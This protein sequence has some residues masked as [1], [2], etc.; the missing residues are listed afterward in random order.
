MRRRLAALLLAVPAAAA[1][2]GSPDVIDITAVAVEG[3]TVAEC[4]D[5]AGRLA[6]QSRALSLAT[7]P[8]IDL[9][10]GM[11]TFYDHVMRLDAN[12]ELN[13]TAQLST[14]YVAGHDAGG[15]EHRRVVTP[16]VRVEVSRPWGTPADAPSRISIAWLWLSRMAESA[17]RPG[18]PLV[19]SPLLHRFDV[20]GEVETRYG[21]WGHAV[22]PCRAGRDGRW[23]GAVMVWTYLPP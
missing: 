15:V 14:V 2:Q 23:A 12:G 20:S 7:A 8:P 19:Q 21:S 1:A 22:A 13:S 6:A 3:A 4:T 11:R 9:V 17:E 16:F 18:G 5:R 10:A